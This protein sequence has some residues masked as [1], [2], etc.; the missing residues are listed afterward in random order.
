[1]HNSHDSEKIALMKLEQTTWET[2]SSSPHCRRMIHFIFGCSTSDVRNPV[3]YCTLSTDCGIEGSDRKLSPDT[4]EISPDPLICWNLKEPMES[5][6]MS[7][8]W[9]SKRCQ[10]VTQQPSSL[11]DKVIN[12]WQLDSRS[13]LEAVNEPNLNAIST[14]DFYIDDEIEDVDFV[15]ATTEK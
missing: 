7:R 6:E 9:E 1:M 10:L 14:Q 4:L 13:L 11:I 15:N 8:D 12:N 2:C 5:F 3:D